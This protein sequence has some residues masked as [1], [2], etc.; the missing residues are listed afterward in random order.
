MATGATRK[1][2]PQP[3]SSRG[4]SWLRRLFAG[5][6][7]GGLLALVGVAGWQLLSL[8]VNRVVVSGDVQQLSRDELMAVISD[9][10]S[11]GFLWLDLQTIRE[12]LEALPWV[13]RAVV[14]RQ[15]PDSIEVQVV[16][17]RPIAHWGNDA[18]LNHAGDVFRPGNIQPL[19]GLPTLSGPAGSQGELMTRYKK[20]QEQ[21]QPLGLKVSALEMSSRGGLTAQ[22]VNGGELVFGRDELEEKLTRLSFI[23]RARLAARREELARVD[24]R[25]SQG[26]A[27]A[28]RT[29]RKQET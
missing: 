8:P 28:W 11:G 5:A 20:V 23:Y 10:L 14:R 17:Q 12:P 24:L 26:A 1:P 7:G 22:L 15:W 4:G 2:R 3:R 19:A 13:H 21:L 18:Y 29:D 27:V 25:Y 16:E 6:L 9:S